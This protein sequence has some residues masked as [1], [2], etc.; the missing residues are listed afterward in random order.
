MKTK[1]VE[2]KSNIVY[3]TGLGKMCPE[4]KRPVAQCS[5]RKNSQIQTGDGIVRIG[6]STKGRGGK[7]VSLIKGVPL[8][9]DELQ[10][11]SKELKQKC[12]TGGTV[13]A[14]IIEIQGDHRDTLV[15]ELEK[16]GFTVKR[17]GG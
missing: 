2:N 1:Q 7:F 5:C 6:R 15:Q 16:R 17:S 10:L 12:G 13:K 8:N 14:G 11:L 4:C 9:P 3:S